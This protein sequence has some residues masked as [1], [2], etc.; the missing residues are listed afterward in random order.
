[1]TA[2]TFIANCLTVG[3]KIFLPK[4]L[5]SVEGFS[6]ALVWIPKAQ[7]AI[8]LVVNLAVMSLQS[9]ASSFS[10]DFSM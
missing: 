5:N 3:S 2:I 1:M 9:K 10:A 8:I 6:R 7:E 4:T